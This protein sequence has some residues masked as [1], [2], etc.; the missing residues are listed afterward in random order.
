MPCAFIRDYI[1]EMNRARD[2]N[3]AVTSAS[4][5]PPLSFIKKY[6]IAE[7][8]GVYSTFYGR[9]ILRA[10]ICPTYAITLIYLKPEI[11]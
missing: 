1:T 10:R 8:A 4:L 9:K 11:P 3:A 7:A 5:F 2:K 6:R